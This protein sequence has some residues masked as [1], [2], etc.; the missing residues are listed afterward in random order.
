LIEYDDKVVVPITTTR[1]ERENNKTEQNSNRNSFDSQRDS[2]ERIP[3][4]P[5][6]L[7]K[8]DLQHLSSSALEELQNEISEILEKRGHSPARYAAKFSTNFHL[9]IQQEHQ[10]TI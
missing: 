1:A 2:N 4:T 8:R 9:F 7:L 3:R 10:E 5:P 6:S